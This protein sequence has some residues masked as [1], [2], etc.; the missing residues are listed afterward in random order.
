VGVSNTIA[1]KPGISKTAVKFDIEA[2][3]SRRANADAQK[4]QVDVQGDEVT[5]SGTVHSLDER[6]TARYSAWGTKGVH[7]VIDNISITY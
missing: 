5:L 7:N 3:L 4:I 1:L 2:A 6:T